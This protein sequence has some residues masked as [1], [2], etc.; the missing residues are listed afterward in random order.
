[1]AATVPSRPTPLL[2]IRLFG[3][4]EVSLHGL[5]LPRLHSRKGHRL[6]ALPTVRHGAQIVRA[7]LAGTHWP[8]SDEPQAL[9]CFPPVKAVSRRQ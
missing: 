3:S 5:P 4:F 1:M 6:L 2:A 8:E 9:A 7:W